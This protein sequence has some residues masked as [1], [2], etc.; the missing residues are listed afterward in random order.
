MRLSTW[1]SRM[2]SIK[3]DYRVHRAAVFIDARSPGLSRFLRGL[4]CGEGELFCRVGLELAII[5]TDDAFG[6]A[7]TGK[8]SAKRVLTYGIESDTADVTAT[9]IQTTPTGGRFELKIHGLSRV[10]ECSLLASSI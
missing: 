2:V 7:L 10:A 4:W 3:T 9:A 1:A 5:N 8:T 6:R